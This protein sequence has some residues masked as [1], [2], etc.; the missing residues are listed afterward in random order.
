MLLNARLVDRLRFACLFRGAS[1]DAAV[2]ALRPYQNADGGFGHALEPDGRTPFSQP[3]TT[4]LAF[5]ILD[6]L[7]RFDHDMVLPACGYLD[8]ISRR[9]GGVPFVHPSIRPHPRA[10]WWQPDDGPE[11]SLLPTAQLVGLLHKHGFDHPWV[12]RATEFCWQRAD[13]L[14]ET[15]GYEARALVCFLDHVP[16]RSRAERVAELL[17][18]LVVDQALV[19]LEVTQPGEVHTPLDFAPSPGSVARRWFDDRTI[20]AHLDA[21]VDEQQPDGGWTF[22]WQTWTPITAFEWRGEVTVRQLA[23]LGRFGRLPLTDH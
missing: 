12:D 1:T 2:A 10:P 7:G 6:E 8:S 23:R 9:D 18:R 22:N 11:G 16:D 21:L 3:L 4:A 20:D 13:A 19:A 14:N 5:D 15:H 17:G